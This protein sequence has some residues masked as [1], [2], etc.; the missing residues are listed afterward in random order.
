MRSSVKFVQALEFFQ[1][2]EAL[3]IN[4]LREALFQSGEGSREPSE[5]LQNDRQANMKGTT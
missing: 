1:L 2:G 4:R 5:P 3:P